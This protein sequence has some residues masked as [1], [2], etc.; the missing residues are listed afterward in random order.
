MNYTI[1]EL[2]TSNISK[3]LVYEALKTSLPF[4]KQ[5]IK[6]KRVFDENDFKIFKYFKQFWENKTVSKFWTVDKVGDNKE[7]QKQFTNSFE[8]QKTVFENSIK[9]VPSNNQK[10]LNRDIETVIKQFEDREVQYKESIE[11]KEKLIEVK[12]EQVNKY[13]LLKQEEKKEK[14]EWINK[15][16]LLQNEKGEWMNKFYNTRMYMILFFILFVISSFWIIF[17]LIK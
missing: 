13:A 12:N 11:Q 16:D 8:T 3:N 14:E 7:T 1:K 15:H 10:E 4:S 2:H 17:L 9:T 5:F 6:N